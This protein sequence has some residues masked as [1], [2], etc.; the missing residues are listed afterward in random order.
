MLLYEVARF[1]EDDIVATGAFQSF[2]IEINGR[3]VRGR[4]EEESRTRR[5]VRHV[6]L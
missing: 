1:S 3:V 4:L 6:E 2:V 5:H